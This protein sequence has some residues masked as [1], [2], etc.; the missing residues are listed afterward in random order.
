MEEFANIKL[1]LKK[2]I[3]EGEKES[4]LS[5][6]SA[7]E[8]FKRM[9]VLIN[10][11]EDANIKVILEGLGE[12]DLKL[13]DDMEK[14]QKKTIMTLFWYDERSKPIEMKRNGEAGEMVTVNMWEG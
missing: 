7:A 11:D 10:A 5:L 6:F 12:A 4:L 9:D 13:G 3:K 8:R 2:N 1:R 14:G